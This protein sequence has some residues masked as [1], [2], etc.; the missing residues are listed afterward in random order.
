MEATLKH[1]GGIIKR[2]SAAAAMDPGDVEVIGE[3]IGIVS[4]GKPIEIGDDYTLQTCD[5]FEM[6][7]KSAD[8]WSDGDVLYW[9]ASE[10][11]LTDT[12]GSNV[13][14]GLAVGDKASGATRA[15]CDINKR[16]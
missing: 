3:R 1:A 9:D 7:A 13:K 11:E 5:V 8:E 2:Y 16:Q 4:G 6:D 15:D 10:R 12:A 14:A